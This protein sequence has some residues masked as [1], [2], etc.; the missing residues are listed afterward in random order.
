MFKG[1]DIIAI[2]SLS[3]NTVLSIISEIGPEGFK[4]FKTSK[5]LTT[6]LRLAPN[7]KVSG[8]KV[9]SSKVGKGSSRLKIAL[10]NAANLPAGRLNRKS[11]RQHTLKRLF[12]EN[13]L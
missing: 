8:G 3:H 7:N 11:Q 13:Q 5:H 9:L 12:Y 4:K 10:R 6:W 2:E 1:I